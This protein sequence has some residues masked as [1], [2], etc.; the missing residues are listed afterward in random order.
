MSITH[1]KRRA[2][3]KLELLKRKV[4]HL[5]HD[6]VDEVHE[7]LDNLEEVLGF[8]LS[9]EDEVELKSHHE[10]DHSDSD[11]DDDVD[12]FDHIDDDAFGGGDTGGGGASSD[13]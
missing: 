9:G 13:W 6:E 10:S 12:L 4:A 8:D 2:V 5:E 7:F 1:K 11:D 3:S